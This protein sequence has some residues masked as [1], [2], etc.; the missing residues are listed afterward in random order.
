MGERLL[1]LVQGL[2]DDAFERLY[3]PVAHVDPPTAAALMD[4]FGRPWWI[5]GGWAI[6]AFTG[7]ERPHEDIDVCV[8]E[9]DVPAVIE[10]FADSHHVWASGG[11]VMCP[12]LSPEQ[13]V[14]SWLHQLWVRE[15]A[16]QPW[17]LD[18]IVTPERDGNWV[19]QRDPSVTYDLERVTWV[20]GDGISYQR[21]EVT[22]AFKAAH[23][24]EKD[25]A[26]LDAVLPL[27]DAP[28][29]LW[30]ID[31]IER[32]HPGHAWL[33]MLKSPGV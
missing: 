20:A 30:L 31:T 15:D 10:H 12:L 7:V 23:D 18:F 8:L 28:A 29:R 33:E 21:P 5:V 4:G 9:C 22:L 6:Q 3:G 32:L 25:R 16:A 19:F 11:G 13:E 1:G 17:L 26:D 14:P 27:L 24:R 2:S